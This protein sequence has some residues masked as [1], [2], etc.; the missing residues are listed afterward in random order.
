METIMKVKKETKKLIDNILEEGIPTGNN[1]EYLDKLVDIQKD[2]CEME[3]G[4][5][6]MRYGNY[7]GRPMGYD[8]YGRDSYGRES[9]NNYGRRGYDMKYQGHN[10]LDKLYDS[11]GRYE[12]SRSSYGNT[13]AS[14]ESLN[15]M[16]ESVVDFM[17][18]LKREAKSQD[19]VDLIK[20]YAQTIVNM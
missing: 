3:E 9:Y 2:I 14:M 8:S 17:S 18:M 12:A 6:S 5:D 16:L 7:G 4:S 13:D 15:Y 20:R 10:Y 1:L 11:Y 19:E